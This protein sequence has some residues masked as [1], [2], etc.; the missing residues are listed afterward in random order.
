MAVAHALGVP[1]PAWLLQ[2]KPRGARSIQ[3]LNNP[4]Q[5]L[6]PCPRHGIHASYGNLSRC[7][8][9]AQMDRRLLHTP[10]WHLQLLSSRLAHTQPCRVVWV[11][12]PHTKSQFF[13]SRALRLM[14]R[15]HCPHASRTYA[16]APCH[17]RCAAPWLALLLNSALGLQCLGLRLGLCH[18][19][20]DCL[21]HLQLLVA[22]T[23]G[24]VGPVD[25]SPGSTVVCRSG[26]CVERGGVRNARG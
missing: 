17:R 15:T 2:K 19:L 8:S 24:L 16:P 7:L 20:A 14:L 18:V 3:I 22:P 1:W 6:P 12:A 25:A 23:P 26:T 11:A 10:S 4:G 9:Q 5:H 21:Q 13:P